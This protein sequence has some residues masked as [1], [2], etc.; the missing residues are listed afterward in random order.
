MADALRLT[1]DRVGKTQVLSASDGGR[2]LGRIVERMPALA[3][4]EGSM[5]SVYDQGRR[6]LPEAIETWRRAVC[7]HVTVPANCVLDL[8]AG[9][10]RFSAL[11]A[12]WLEPSMVAGLEPAAAMR[13]VA[14]QHGRVSHV[15]M[16]GAAAEALPLRDRCVEV[17]WLSNV[18]HHFDDLEAAANELGRVVQHGG[19]VLIRGY[20]P[21]RSEPIL[22][23][24]WFSAAQQAAE[25]FPTFDAVTH[26]FARSKFA[27][28]A[29]DRVKYPWAENLADLRQRAGLR[30]DTTLACLSQEEFR[31]GLEAMDQELAVEP[32]ATRPAESLEL[33][34]L[35]QTQN[36]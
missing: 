29:I 31:A 21:D 9:T 34:V 32:G 5:A 12:D 8:G 2:A 19:R 22:W 30:A 4:Y 20:F 18:I 27:L 33:V 13:R 15:A 24:R 36:G 23:A 16:T 11:L 10:G 14:A 17:A 1:L 25:R 3:D 26:A 7:K 35:A 28:I 6:L